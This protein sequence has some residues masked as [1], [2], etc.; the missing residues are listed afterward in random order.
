M[1]DNSI[2]HDVS[3]ELRDIGI[4]NVKILSTLFSHLLFAFN[5]SLGHEDL[6]RC[7][8][9]PNWQR[10]LLPSACFAFLNQLSE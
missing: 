6:W 3:L 2:V 7:L 10:S 9:H 4:E 5:R 8:C 1:M